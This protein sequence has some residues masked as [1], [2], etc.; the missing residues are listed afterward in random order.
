MPGYTSPE[1]GT[2]VVGSIETVGKFVRAE[3]E[4]GLLKKKRAF[5]YASDGDLGWWYALDGSELS[6]ARTEALRCGYRRWRN[7]QNR[8]ERAKNFACGEG[9]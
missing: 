4:F 6:P 5:A 7:E 3:Y 2:R 9:L 1:W 8:I